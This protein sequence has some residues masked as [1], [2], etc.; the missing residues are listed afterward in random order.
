LLNLLGTS[1]VPPGVKDV[2]VWLTETPA[3]CDFCFQCAVQM[4]LLTY[5]LCADDVAVGTA[6]CAVPSERTVARPGES[7][8]P[9]AVLRHSADARFRNTRHDGEKYATAAECTHI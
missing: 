4:L 2:F 9:T 5:L 6:W 8:R 1:S 7:H 3:P